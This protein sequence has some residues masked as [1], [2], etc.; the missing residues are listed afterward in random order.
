MFA[1]LRRFRVTLLEAF[2]LVTGF[3]LALA[4][5]QKAD[6]V[7]LDIARVLMALLLITVFALAMAWPERREVLLSFMV[8]TFLFLAYDYWANQDGYVQAAAQRHVL[9][10]LTG[11][12][13]YLNRGTPE[14]IVAELLT[15]E[16]AV[17]VGLLSAWVTRSFRAKP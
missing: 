11:N 14:S 16:V 5:L 12:M 3:C 6:I 8:G 7:V 10:Y 1:E 4:L 9:A 2:W 13:T 17:G 15:L